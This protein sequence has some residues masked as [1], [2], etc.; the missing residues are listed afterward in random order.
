MQVSPVQLLAHLH[1]YTEI[2]MIL[3]ALRVCNNSQITDPDVHV[4]KLPKELIAMIENTV[5]QPIHMRQMK[6]LAPEYNC[7]MD[8][9]S[10]PDHFS[11]EELLLI[12]ESINSD[13]DED[14]NLNWRLEWTRHQYPDLK[15]KEIRQKVLEEEFDTDMMHEICEEH[16]RRIRA[17]RKRWCLPQLQSYS[18]VGY[19][20]LR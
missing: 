3:R 14:G 17:W 7:Y 5:V 20:W 11:T 10:G 15:E 18:K 12:H 9:C 19:S 13:M 6:E 1:A 16:D 8:R 2:K 4:T